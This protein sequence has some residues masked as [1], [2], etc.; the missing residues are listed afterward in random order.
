MFNICNNLYQKA[1]ATKSAE[2]GKRTHVLPKNDGRGECHASGKS[3]TEEK[4]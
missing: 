4:P 3:E 2:R 1:K